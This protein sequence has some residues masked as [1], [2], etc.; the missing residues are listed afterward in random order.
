MTFI[1]R[2][3]IVS[4]ASF[5]ENTPFSPG[6]KITTQLKVSHISKSQGSTRWFPGSCEAVVL[7]LSSHLPPRVCAHV[8]VYM[9]TLSRNFLLCFP[10]FVTVLIFSS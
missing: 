8:F 5:Q 3:P 1:A 9:C 6:A 2:V 4:D 10:L 7:L